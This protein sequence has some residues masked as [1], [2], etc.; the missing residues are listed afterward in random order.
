MISYITERINLDRYSTYDKLR[1]LALV[2]LLFSIPISRS[3]PHAMAVL[4]LLIFLREGQFKS[5]WNE[6]KDNPIFWAFA[7]YFIVFPLSLLWSD[8]LAWSW[9]ILRGQLR[10][11]VVPIALLAM[12]REWIPIGITAFVAGVT[13][14]EAT[15]Y[16]V[17]F[18][19]IEIDGVDPANPTPFYHHVHYNPMLAWAFYLLMHTLLFGNASRYTKYLMVFFIITI[20]VN[21]FI[22]GGR[23][24]QIAYFV[25]LILITMQYFALKKMLLQGVLIAAGA[26]VLIFSLAYT[27]SELFQQ[28]VNLAVDEVRNYTPDTRTSVGLRLSFA[29]NTLY[30]AFNRSWPEMIFGSGIGDF[31]EDYTASLRHEGA[32]KLYAERRRGSTHPHNQYLYHLGA[33]GLLGLFTLLALYAVLT[34]YAVGI[35]DEYSRQRVALIILMLVTMIPDTAMMSRPIAYMFAIFTAMYYFNV[36]FGKSL[37]KDSSITSQAEK[38]E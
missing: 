34:R 12:R 2:A 5:A 28:R 7:A 15:S 23:N 22:T 38:R 3:M 32:E 26:S 29:E 35:K 24:G 6:W 30:M 11:L 31:P 10:Y 4:L 36:R 9:E 33:L 18:E 19:L 13:F 25:M 14:T 37:H 20:S 21:M 16:L 27:S 1:L 8:N 17:W